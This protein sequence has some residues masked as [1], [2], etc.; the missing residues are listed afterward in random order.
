MNWV[1]ESFFVLKHSFSKYSF[2]KDLFSVK[3]NFCKVQQSD[4]WPFYLHNCRKNLI[5]GSWI[6]LNNCKKNVQ[7]R[8]RICQIASETVLKEYF[9]FYKGCQV[10]L[11]SEKE[12]HHGKTEVDSSG[13]SRPS[14]KGKGGG[15]RKWMI[16]FCVPCR[17]FCDFFFFIQNKGS[18]GH[19]PLPEI[20]HYTGRKKEQL[21][22]AYYWSHNL[23]FS[24]SVLS[25]AW[26]LAFKHAI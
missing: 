17:L 14:A 5:W 22:S 13:A 1:L 8:A 3:T 6:P 24:I 10:V 25:N 4:T 18:A 9:E 21:T 20:H 26:V 2:D 15:G 11:F 16:A 12:R 19:R 23:L 7:L